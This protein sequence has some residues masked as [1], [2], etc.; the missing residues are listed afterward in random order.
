M[1]IR[2]SRSTGQSSRFPLTDFPRLRS[3]FFLI[4]AE[5]LAIVLDESL[6]HIMSNLT[7]CPEKAVEACDGLN[8][9]DERKDG[10]TVT[11]LAPADDTGTG[12]QQ[13]RRAL[14]WKID[15]VM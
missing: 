1:P 15:I 12:D 14:L 10:E 7:I 5:E 3:R 6:N 13:H 9:V 8:D 2:S 4:F 11:S